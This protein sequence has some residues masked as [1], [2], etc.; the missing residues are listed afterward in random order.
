MIHRLLLNPPRR[1]VRPISQ[2]LFRLFHRLR[3]MARGAPVASRASRFYVSAKG[4]Q[5][6]LHRFE[7]Y[8]A[9]V[10]FESGIADL[11]EQLEGGSGA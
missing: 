5:L 11:L 2:M 4:S 8:D 6:A 3:C 10:L 9:G 7:P 1:H